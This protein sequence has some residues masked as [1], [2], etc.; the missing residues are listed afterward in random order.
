MD[1]TKLHYGIR[2]YALD[3][4]REALQTIDTSYEN[5]VYTTVL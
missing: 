5:V 1:D 2:E 4:I 3:G